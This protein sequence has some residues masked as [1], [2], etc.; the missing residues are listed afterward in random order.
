MDIIQ[1]GKMTKI[2][3]MKITDLMMIGAAILLLVVANL[4]TIAT[5]KQKAMKMIEDDRDNYNSVM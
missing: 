5:V 4:R 2:G 1:N 3:G